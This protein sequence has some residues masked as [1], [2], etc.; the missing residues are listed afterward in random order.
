MI[1]PF[2]DDGNLSFG[3]LRELTD[4]LIRN[5]LADS[6]VLTGSTGEF[7]T[8][9][10]EERVDVW[11]AIR[12]ANR[13]RLP[14]I[15]G[16]GGSSTRQAIKLTQRA[17]EM[18]FELVMVVAPYYSKASQEGIYRHFRAVAESASIPIM[19]YNIP[20]FTGVNVD[21][22]T[23][24]RLLEIPN[25]VGIKEEAGINPI[26]ST[27][28]VLAAREAGRDDFTLYCG[29][30][31]MVL[32]VLLQGGVGVVTGGS[33]VVGKQ[34]KA[35]IAAFLNGEIGRASELYLGM[36]PFFKALGQ[37]GRVSPFPILRA[38][39]EATS[40]LRIGPPRLPLAPATADEVSVIKRVMDAI[41]S[42]EPAKA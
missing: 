33:H 12:E 20:L 24:R 30:D 25:I 29:D 27:D 28:Y 22:P 36:A 14:M 5:D 39:L 6:L 34:M 2:D 4:Y 1:T 7:Y 40:G 21:T 37:N 32:Q 11:S 41:L 26:Q 19:L 3:T 18:G 10:D 42:G 13:D 38:A 9:D 15:V 8:M 23:L 17:Q 31:T 16:T 35:M